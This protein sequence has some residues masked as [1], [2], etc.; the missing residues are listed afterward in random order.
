MQRNVSFKIVV[1]V[2]SGLRTK[3][4]DEWGTGHGLG[5]KKSEQREGEEEK[6]LNGYELCILHYVGTYDFFF[7]NVRCTAADPLRQNG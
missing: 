6:D 7:F 1:L 3:A 2:A 4:Q 5:R